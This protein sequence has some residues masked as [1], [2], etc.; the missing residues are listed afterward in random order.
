[1]IS[2][3][4]FR[5]L[6][7]VRSR[8]TRFASTYVDLRSDTVTLPS[9][10]MKEA[11]MD[12]PVGDDVMGEDPTVLALEEYM[13]DLFGKEKGLFVPTGTMANLVATMSHCHGRASEVRLAPNSF[14]ILS[15]L[16]SSHVVDHYW[17]GFT[18]QSVG[19]WEYSKPGWCEQ[20]RSF[21][22]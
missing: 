8:L 5:K 10:A 4:A 14:R 9:R 12:A 15:T 21:R 2:A 22:R 17:L 3:T 6:T 7:L 19:R 20:K 18:Y 16:M 1:M 13:A 11:A